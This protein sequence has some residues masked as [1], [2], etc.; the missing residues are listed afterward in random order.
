MTRA[1]IAASVLC[2]VLMLAG[3]TGPVAEAAVR[4]GNQG[5]Q[6]GWSVDD[7]GRVNFLHSASQQFPIMRDAGAGWVRVHFRLGACLSTWGPQPPACGTADGASA[8]AVYDL[9]V[10]NALA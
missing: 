3:P 5:L 6:G 4:Q 1:P 10:Q 7:G 8:L 9:V 2:I